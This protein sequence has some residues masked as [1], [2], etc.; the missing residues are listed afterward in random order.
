[1]RLL[2]IYLPL[3]IRTRRDLEIGEAEQERVVFDLSGPSAASW[4][5]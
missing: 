2:G 3:H 5:A 1:M 4:L